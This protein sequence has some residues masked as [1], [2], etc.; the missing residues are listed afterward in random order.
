M[1][2]RIVSINQ[3]QKN[4]SKELN[5][6]HQKEFSNWHNIGIIYP[7]LQKNLH[8]QGINEVFAQVIT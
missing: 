1:I 6:I 8:E 7:I 4:F 2:L 5:I 3:S